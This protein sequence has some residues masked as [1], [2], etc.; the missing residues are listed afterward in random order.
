MEVQSQIFDVDTTNFEEAVLKGSEERVIVVDFWA[1]WC[2]P[3][4]TLGPILEEVVT[5]MGAGI[6]LAKVNVDENQQLAM[7][8]RVQGI[9]AVKVVHKGQLVDEFTGAVPREQIEAALR[10]HVPDAPPS[11]A[12]LLEEEAARA[13]EQL[14]GGD[15]ASAAADFERILAEDPEAATALVG[16]ARIRLLEGDF[17]AVRELVARL[18]LGTPEYD[19]GQALLTHLGFHRICE[20][21]GGH[22]ACTENVLAHPDD[23]EAHYALGCCAA[24][25]GDYETAL[26]E[27][28]GVIEAKRDFKDGAAKDA[29]VSVF[30][31]LG[32]QHEVV[33]DYPQRLYR[34]LY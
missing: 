15:L 19:Q 17:D 10:K 13:R 27:W 11:E 34:T 16:L 4:K 1:P 31:L 25:Q 7:A 26:K 3:C 2:E 23:L 30:H 29:M 24:V 20:A 22:R 12:E 6:A 8:F 21:G 9:P 14:E 18:E 28:F 33:G 5:S 32:R